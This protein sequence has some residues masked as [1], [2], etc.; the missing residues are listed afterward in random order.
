MNN[1]QAMTKGESHRRPVRRQRGFTLVELLVVIAI[2]GILVALLLPAIQAAREAARRTQC[3][4]HIKQI[5][6]AMHNH[7]TNQKVFPSGGIGPWPKIENYVSGGRPYGAEKQGLS[8]AFQILP[9]L[10]ENAVH[11]IVTTPQ[12]YE[13][14]VDIYFCPSR[15]GPT[16]DPA[17]TAFLMDYAAAVPAKARHQVGQD[18]YDPDYLSIFN[19]DTRGCWKG[20]FWSGPNNPWYETAPSPSINAATNDNQTTAASLG[21]GYAGH[22]GVIVRSNYCAICDATKRTTGFYQPIT[23]GKIPDGSSKVFV[24]GEKRLIP[25]LYFSGSW[26]DDRGWSDGWDPDTLRSTICEFGQDR[27]IHPAES[28]VAGLRFGSAHPSTMNAA[29][30]DGSVRSIDYSIG[31]ELLNKLAHRMDGDVAELESQ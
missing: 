3:K 23:F 8:W 29:F 17:S 16:R 26:H 28:P 6:L 18:D 12:M 2:I 9:Y 19:R 4:N 1:T 27:E 14:A 11:G 10:E 13:A 22:W 24:I 15:R 30:A 25:S 5:I 21:A 31:Q 7:V 20:E